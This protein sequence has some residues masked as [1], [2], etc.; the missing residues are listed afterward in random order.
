MSVNGHVS[1]QKC[2]WMDMFVG[3][4]V[5]EQTYKWA[6][7]SKSLLG[8]LQEYDKRMMMMMVMCAAC[9]Q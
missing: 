8:R 6:N 4:H 2:Q 1:G 5:S 3:K 9:P 7:K